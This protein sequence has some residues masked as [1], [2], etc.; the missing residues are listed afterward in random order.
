MPT[1]ILRDDGQ[2]TIPESIREARGLQ[3]GARI[4]VVLTDDRVELRPANADLTALDGLLDRSDRESISVEAMQE[5]IEN[6]T[7]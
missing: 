4:E 5:A 3:S 2:T 7:G 6:A 1:S